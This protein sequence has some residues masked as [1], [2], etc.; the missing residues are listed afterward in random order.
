MLFRRHVVGLGVVAGDVGQDEIVSHVGGIARPGD[1]V[2][3]VD[4][5][6]QRLPA[7]EALAL[8][9][10]RQNGTVGFQVRPLVAEKEGAQVGHAAD[11]VDVHLL[12]EPHP[13]AYTYPQAVAEKWLVDFR[14]YQAQT[15]FQ[16]RG[17]K[18]ADLS[19][20]DRATL[21]VQGLDPDSLDYAGTDLEVLVSNRDT[22]RRQWEEI[23]EVCIKDRGGHLLGKTIIFAMTKTHAERVRDVFEEMFPEHVGLLQVV[24]SGMERVHDGSYG[25]GLITKFK[26]QD[27][28]RI[29]VSVDMLDTGIDVPEVVNLVFMK[30]VQS[31]IKLWQMIGRG[32]RNQE[33][34]RFFDRLPNGKK[35]EFLIVDFWQND[36]GK[37]TEDRVPPELPVLVRLFNTRLDILAATLNQR[38]GAAHQQAVVEKH[39]L[40]RLHP[41]PGKNQIEVYGVLLAVDRGEHRSRGQIAEKRGRLLAPIVRNPADAACCGD[42]NKLVLPEA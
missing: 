41:C 11:V 22:L 8:L 35:T 42:H 7:V 23:M 19:E 20:E 5:A 40:G 3:D 29:A 26:K 37:Q 32:T 28:P 21:M 15:G 4:A 31:R 33:A 25:D 18:G 27:K 13:C 30:P 14:L 39:P 17:I 9:D 6:G 24:Y 10:V 36:F 12:D 38:D 2:V 1:E 34:C 16:R